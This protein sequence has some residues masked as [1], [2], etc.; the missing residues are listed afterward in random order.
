MVRQLDSLAY[1]K[2]KIKGDNWKYD[3]KK[4]ISLL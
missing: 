2:P 3:S 4:E 1:E